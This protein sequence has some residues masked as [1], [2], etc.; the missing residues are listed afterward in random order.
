MRIVSTFPSGTEIVAALGLADCLVGVSH[1]CE[2]PEDVLDV[3]K[4]TSSDLDGW[5]DPAA[6]DAEVS[7]RIRKGLPVY[8]LHRDV[9]AELRPDYIIGQDVCN[10]CAVPA[11]DAQIAGAHLDNPAPTISLQ[12]NRLDDIFLNI[13]QVADFLGVSQRGENLV[14]NVQRRLAQV[15]D[16]VS[17]LPRPKVF[18]VEWIDPLMNAGAWI[19][20][21]IVAAGGDPVL[22]EGGGPVRRLSLE[23]VE[24]A[25]PD[26]VLVAAC[27]WSLD[28]TESHMSRLTSHPSWGRLPAVR[29]GRVYL[30]DGSMCS[31]H[32]PRV[33]DGVELI[34]RL[35]HPQAFGP[36]DELAVDPKDARRFAQ[37]EAASGAVGPA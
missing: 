21:L 3:P 16:A 1:Q 7:R 13:R 15:A 37:A 18:W 34:A 26:V 31:K 30:L 22:T 23:E 4:V 24:A 2:W 20:D 11:G 35:I 8:E 32:S 9:L 27:G 14:A 19:P 6:I 33:A 5:T 17:G 10:V 36:A 28:E 12:A 29:Q 25:A